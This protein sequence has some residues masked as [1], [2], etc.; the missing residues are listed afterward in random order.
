MLWFAKY[1]TPLRKGNHYSY[2][3]VCLGWLR[4]PGPPGEW[5]FQLIQG[6][7][8]A[9][10]SKGFLYWCT[11]LHVHLICT[12]APRFPL[13]IGNTWFTTL[14][15]CIYTC[16]SRL[17]NVAK[18]AAWGSRQSGLQ[19]GL[20]WVET[21]VSH[22]ASVCL[23]WS[24]GGWGRAM[25]DGQNRWSGVRDSGFPLWNEQVTRIKGTALGIQSM[26]L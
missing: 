20:S 13:H 22:L 7:A 12:T 14:E 25:G 8:Q 18:E 24:D 3:S 17:G 23:T 26:T 6:F 5:I 21:K 4:F 2:P 11:P 16:V 9:L 15:L 1:S 10:P 19:I